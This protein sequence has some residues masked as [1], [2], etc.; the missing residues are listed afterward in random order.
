MKVRSYTDVL[1]RIQAVASGDRSWRVS[2]IALLSYP[3]GRYPLVA[4]C[5]PGEAGAP[6]L[7]LSAGIHGDEAAGV[8]ALLRFL[9]SNL[10]RRFASVPLTVLPCQ[11]PFGYERHSRFNGCGLDLNRQFDKPDT[12]AQE[13][14][15]LRRFLLERRPDLVVE[16]HEDADADGFYLWEIKRPGRPEIGRG[17]VD[18]ISG[19]HPVTAA[20]TVEGC[21]VT[22]SVAHPTAERIRRIGGWSHTYFLFRNGTPHCLTPETPS[23]APFEARV[24][25]HLTAIRT[26]L[27][28]TG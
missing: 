6:C 8:E 12:P 23:S 2:E 13:S 24:D 19:A 4:L 21:F 11:N 16:C 3:S 27:E 14:I 18:R 15:A 1:H 9:E 17:V 10:P 25:M 7:S 20:R 5:R 26:V 28:M 22:A